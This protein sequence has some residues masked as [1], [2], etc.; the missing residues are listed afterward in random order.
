MPDGSIQ[1]S[2]GNTASVNEGDRLNGS[3]IK[4]AGYKKVGRQDFWRFNA[5]LDK[6]KEKD[7]T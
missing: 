3:R 5:V 2:N 1:K 7:P 4:E 6:N